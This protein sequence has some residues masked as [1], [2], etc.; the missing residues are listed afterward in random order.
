MSISITRKDFL[1]YVRVQ[2]DG[3]YNM[4]DQRAREM[5]NLSKEQWLIIQT[6]YNKLNKAWSKDNEND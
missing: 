5:T 1:E 3:S 4:L 2:K 6:D